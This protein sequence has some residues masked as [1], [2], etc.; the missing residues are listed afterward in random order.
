MTLL[1]KQTEI[2][3]ALSQQINTIQKNKTIPINTF[4]ASPEAINPISAKSIQTYKKIVNLAPTITTLQNDIFRDTNKNI[5]ID[6]DDSRDNEDLVI[7]I[8]ED[9]GFANKNNENISENN[10]CELIV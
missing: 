9:E 2:I 3:K 1:K 10:E 6:G 4:A 5:D 7:D 8:K